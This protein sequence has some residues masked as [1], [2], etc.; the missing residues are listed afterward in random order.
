[1]TGKILGGMYAQQA[2]QTLLPLVQTFRAEFIGRFLD[3]KSGMWGPA[4]N[5]STWGARDGPMGIL[6]DLFL[7]F[8]FMLVYQVFSDPL[9]SFI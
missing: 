9:S 8:V 4:K 2:E 6:S 1:M 5:L 3:V 7:S